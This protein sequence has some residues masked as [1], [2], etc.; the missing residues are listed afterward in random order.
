MAGS[1][2]TSGK[3]AQKR[4]PA[5]EPEGTSHAEKRGRLAEDA[6]AD[7]ASGSGRLLASHKGFKVFSCDV[8]A[9]SGHTM[10]ET[11]W[12]LNYQEISEGKTHKWFL[13]GVRELIDQEQHFPSQSHGF[14][15]TL[16]NIHRAHPK[17]VYA[18]AS[19]ARPLA[20]RVYPPGM[21]A[22]I[23]LHGSWPLHASK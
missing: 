15:R 16:T 14:S 10:S 2:E 11:P 20:W 1:K 7:C 17:L 23:Q 19:C 8:K 5:D 18:C 4:R 12:E 9:R 21:C 22:G 3:Q 6:E 13:K